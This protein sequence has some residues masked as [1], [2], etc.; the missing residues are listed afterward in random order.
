MLCTTFLDLRKALILADLGKIRRE[1]A[2]DLRRFN[3][4]QFSDFVKHWVA[5]LIR[6][7]EETRH[8][9]DPT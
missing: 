4:E 3:L 7:E 6:P 8:A 2:G 5:Q 9:G 1:R